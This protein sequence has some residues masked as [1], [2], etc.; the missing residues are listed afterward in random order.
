MLNDASGE[1]QH[2]NLYCRHGRPVG[3][4]REF[5]STIVLW[6]D[7]RTEFRDNRPDY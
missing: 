1:F 7:F 6:P 5:E 2:R 3:S 4:D